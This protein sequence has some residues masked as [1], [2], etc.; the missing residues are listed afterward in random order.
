[1]R[2]LRFFKESG[3]VNQVAKIFTANI[4][5]VEQISAGHHPV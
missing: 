5:E 2:F 1:M 3:K 4:A